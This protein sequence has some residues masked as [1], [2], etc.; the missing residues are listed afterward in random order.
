MSAPFLHGCSQSGNQDIVHFRVVGPVYSF[1]QQLRFVASQD[2]KKRFAVPLQGILRIRILRQRW[3]GCTFHALPIGPLVL[4][5]RALRIGRELTRPSKV[6]IGFRGK[7][8]V[9]PFAGLLVPE[10]DIFHQDPPRYTVDDGMMN[11]DKQM[12]AVRAAEQARFYKR[13]VSQPDPALNFVRLRFDRVSRIRSLPKIGD[14]QA[15]HLAFPDSAI[16]GRI[17]VLRFA[18]GHP[19]RI[20]MLR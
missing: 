8:D 7:T 6:G 15:V 5:V 12:I 1:Q 2:R 19:Q 9:F 20:V 11:R 18:E 13:P 17:A 3:H 4:H 14:F 10:R 16:P